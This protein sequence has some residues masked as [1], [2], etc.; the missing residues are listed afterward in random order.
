MGTHIAFLGTGVM[1]VGMAGRLLDA[2][3]DLT[4]YNRTAAKADPLAAKGAVLAASPREAA[5]GANAIFA[6]VGDDDASRAV[7]TGPDGALAGECA[8]GAFAIE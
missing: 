7:W 2:G 5:V 8:E 1:G 4:V 6:M 3:H